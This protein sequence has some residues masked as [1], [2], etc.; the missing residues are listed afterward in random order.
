MKK[1]ILPGLFVTS[2]YFVNAQVE[3][4]GVSQGTGQME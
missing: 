3:Q 1:L 2:F 4:P